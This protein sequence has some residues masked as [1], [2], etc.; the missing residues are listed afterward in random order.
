MIKKLIVTTC[1][2]AILAVSAYSEV[3]T[4]IPD[5]DLSLD[6]LV[7][8]TQIIGAANVLN[9]SAD[10]SASLVN[11]SVAMLELSQSLLVAGSNVNTEY[12]VAM[13][14]LSQDILEMADKIGEM[15]DRILVMADN[16]GDMSDRILE[17]QMI[18]SENARITQENILQAQINLQKLL[19]K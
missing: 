6:T 8:T 3:C 14:Q 15:A 10:L 7:S 18:Q 13:L 5:D 4:T 17:T 19:D 1:S 9:D 11:N 16:I 12:V 2:L